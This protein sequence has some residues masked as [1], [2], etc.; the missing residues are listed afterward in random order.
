M[1]IYQ[2]IKSDHVKLKSLL[3]DLVGLERD[4]EFRE[5]LIEDLGKHLIPHI[6]AEESIFYNTLRGVHADKKLLFHA[7]QEHIEI[8]GAF[9]SL[10]VLDKFKLNWLP[11]ANKLR[12]LVF[13]HIQNEE[14]ELFNEAQNAFT[15]DESKL[16]EVS[17]QE[18]K[19]KIENDGIFKNSFEIVFN[20]LPPNI[21]SKMANFVKKDESRP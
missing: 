4:D 16:L 11:T 18:L 5:T 14:F 17:F 8:E 13:Q 21:S 20:M 19:L 12:N 7:F 10:Q 6:R 9:R 1:S 15:E 2:A 3:N